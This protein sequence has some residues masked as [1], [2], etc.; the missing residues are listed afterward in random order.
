MHSR[1]RIEPLLLL[2]V[3]IALINGTDPTIGESLNSTVSEVENSIES[4]KQAV[5]NSTGTLNISEVNT[6]VPPVVQ[7]TEPAVTTTQG[8]SAPTTTSVMTTTTTTT[9]AT[10]VTTTSTT[11]VT[12]GS[13]PD[14]GAA[15]SYD[16]PP[17][18]SQFPLSPHQ[19][20]YD[21]N[22][23]I[24]K[25][26]PFG[27][28]FEPAGN[29]RFRCTP[30]QRTLDV[31]TIYA[32]FYGDSECIEDK[33]NKLHFNY[34]PNDS[35]FG[36]NQTFQ[37]S[38]EQGDQ[39]FVI[40][41][42][43]L[44]VL[45]EGGFM[46]VFD[47][48]CVEVDTKSRLLAKACDEVTPIILQSTA[49]LIYIG[50][51]IASVTLLFTCLAYAL[52]PRLNDAFGYL[53]AGHSGAFLV[54]LIMMTLAVC[55]ER[56]IE[57]SNVDVVQI[58][59]QIFL[60][61]SIYAFVFMNVFNYAYAAY[62]LPNGLEFDTKN[63]R[64]MFVCLGVLYT[65]TLI[66][67]FLPWRHSLIFHLILYIYYLVIAVVLYLS[68]R[69]IR[70]L[71]D[72]KFVRFTVSQQNYNELTYT[73][74]VN[75]QP[76]INGERLKDV[77][78]LNRLCTIEA[79]F[80]L[81]CWI[82]FSSLARSIDSQHDIFRI[83]AAYAVIFQGLLIGVLFVGG[84][85]KWTIIREC[86]NYSGSIDLRALEMEREMLTLERKTPLPT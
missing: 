45:E 28:I 13:P 68:H 20:V 2:L 65:I 69:T 55:G 41:N 85:K 33:E 58:F 53:L 47:W 75:A 4:S 79:I 74:A 36:N 9:R 56:C 83:G 62:Y 32:V 10:K 70:T 82:M 77:R 39:L 48:Y 26:C 17:N 52:V 21:K 76:R 18:C 30:G 19:P 78:G 51:V 59:A 16:T 22:S 64:D 44:L 12:P 37:Y 5:A 72:S 35:C 3:C 86:W 50:M 80:T 29:G 1:V 49:V 38:K 34:Q 42:G 25:C 84:R 61:S 7:T 73:E 27:E 67:L 8:V 81:V 54:G 71:A 31:E 23:L 57:P 15:E 14:V 63:K 11:V 43:S 60:M 24:N 46:S 40:Q 66:P 6:Q